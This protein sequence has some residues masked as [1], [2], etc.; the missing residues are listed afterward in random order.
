MHGIRPVLAVVGEQQHF[1][2]LQ[3]AVGQHPAAAAVGECPA[4]GTA[5]G[6]GGDKELDKVSGSGLPADVGVGVDQDFGDRDVAGAGG[7]E[8]L[9]H[10]RRRRSKR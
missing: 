5:G 1:A 7:G 2:G 9:P 4:D 10:L 3:D 6:I 8:G